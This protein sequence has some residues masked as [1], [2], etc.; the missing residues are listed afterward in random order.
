[1]AAK[2]FNLR[3]VFAEILDETHRSSS[4]STSAEPNYK[5]S[6]LEVNRNLMGFTKSEQ[7]PIPPNQ[8]LMLEPPRSSPPFSEASMWPDDRSGREW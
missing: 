3:M 8:G 2:H 5:G 7:N 6:D 1:M 4:A